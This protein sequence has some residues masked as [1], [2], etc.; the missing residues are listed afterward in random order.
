MGRY[1][2]LVVLSALVFA[3]AAAAQQMDDGQMMGNDMMSASASASPLPGTGGMPLLSAAA[4]ALI[5]GSGIVAVAVVR[6]SS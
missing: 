4:L 1:V 3:P 6:R 5:A 2:Y